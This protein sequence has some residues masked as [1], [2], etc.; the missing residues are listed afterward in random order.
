M[1]LNEGDTARGVGN[2]TTSQE[3]ASLS[4]TATC[5]EGALIA[6]P[7]AA[8]AALSGKPEPLASATTA[9][10]FTEVVSKKCKEHSKCSRSVARKVARSRRSQTRKVVAPMAQSLA[11]LNPS[12]LLWWLQ[13]QSRRSMSLRT[14][15]GILFVN[16]V[17]V[18]IVTAP[19]CQI[20]C[21]L[22]QARGLQSWRLP[23]RQL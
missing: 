20:L 21:I 22:P 14:A 4:A 9:A 17:R 19:Q 12:A 6:G 16:N 1:S 5:G 11:S 2:S 7:A 8:V 18:S 13:M 3:L 15:R 10:P 23:F